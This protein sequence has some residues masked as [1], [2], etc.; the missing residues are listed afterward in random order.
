MSGEGVI[1]KLMSIARS[2]IISNNV[3]YTR[4]STRTCQLII[5]IASNSEAVY[6]YHLTSVDKLTELLLEL[7]LG[8]SFINPNLEALFKEL[9][10]KINA[11][12]AIYCW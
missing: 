2:M 8:Q 6:P 10:A 12:L 9:H 1:D 7:L 3:Q 5:A 11:S 4:V